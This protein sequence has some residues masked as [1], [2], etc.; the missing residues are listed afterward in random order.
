MS[1]TLPRL[2]ALLFA[3]AGLVAAE[4]IAVIDLESVFSES[5]LVEVR[6]QQLRE[7]AAAARTTMEERAKEVSSL[8]TETKIRPK[9]HPKYAEYKE[10]LEIAKLKAKIF[11]ENQQELINQRE[12]E[13]L[14]SSYQ[15]MRLLLADFARERQ[16]SLVLLVNSGGLNA[17]R[18][19]ELRLE[20]A[21]RSVLYHAPELDLT[22][23]FLA[24]ADG[25][26]VAEEAVPAAGPAATTEP[27]TDGGG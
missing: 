4:R 10:R 19:P 26:F 25:R 17:T 18:V 20:L 13:L 5:Q 27:G 8:E 21:Q 3:V 2:F 7:M 23:E 22:K 6:S 12:L 16:L 9:S 11:A 24:F 14:R 1:A 15:D